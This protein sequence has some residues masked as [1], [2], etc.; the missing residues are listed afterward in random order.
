MMSCREATEL[1]SRSLDQPLPWRRRLALRLHLTL[2]SLCRA[3]EVQWRLLRAACAA[4]PGP[5]RPVDGEPS[6]AS[7]DRRPG[8]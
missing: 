7:S 3:C 4:Y 2:C 5:E 1:L 6:H 8:P